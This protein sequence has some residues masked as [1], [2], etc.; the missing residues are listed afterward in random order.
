MSVEAGKQEVKDENIQV[1]EINAQAEK[2]YKKGTDCKEVVAEYDRSSEEDES[3]SEDS[4][5]DARIYI[6][7]KCEYCKYTTE[8]EYDE[9]RNVLICEWCFAE[10]NYVKEN[11]KKEHV[12]YLD[13]NE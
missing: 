12:R 6:K 1:I 5:P 3:N 10:E 2:S 9:E 13:N 8:R 4:E 11:K 7:K